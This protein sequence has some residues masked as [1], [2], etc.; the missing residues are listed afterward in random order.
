MYDSKIA[1]ANRQ[2][3][4]F[5]LLMDFVSAETLTAALSSRYEGAKR[6]FSVETMV[7]GSFPLQYHSKLERKLAWKPLFD[8]FFRNLFPGLP[9]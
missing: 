8:H 5:P 3:N 9:F 4:H 7:A 6:D 2:K 1:K